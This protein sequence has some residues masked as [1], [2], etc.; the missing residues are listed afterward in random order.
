MELTRECFQNFTSS[1]GALLTLMPM[2]ESFTSFHLLFLSFKAL[3]IRIRKY[4]G[5]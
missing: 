1:G 3:L 5:F 2:V 4:R